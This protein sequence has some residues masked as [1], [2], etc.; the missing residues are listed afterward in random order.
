MATPTLLYLPAWVQPTNLNVLSPVIQTVEGG[1]FASRKL[2]SSYMHRQMSVERFLF[3]AEL[4][5]FEHFIRS[6]CDEGHKPFNDKFIDENGVLQ[7]A[8]I[9]L[10]NGAY[11]VVTDSRNHRLTCRIE[12]IDTYA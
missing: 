2:S 3:R 9:K 8:K 1:K 12:I 4:P 7:T 6:V 10:I 11:S 5:Y